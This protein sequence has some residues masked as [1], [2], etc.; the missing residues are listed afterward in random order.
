MHIQQ[1]FLGKDCV[2]HH[3]L[4]N[5]PTLKVQN[6]DTI[7]DYT[8][9]MNLNEINQPSRNND[10]TYRTYTFDKHYSGA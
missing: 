6:D 1:R 5:H 7:R 8:E 10:H 2:A 3:T 4:V 9:I